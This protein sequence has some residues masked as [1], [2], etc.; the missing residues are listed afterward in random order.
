MSFQV[1]HDVIGN[2]VALFFSQFFTKSAHKFAR[3]PKCECDG[4]AQHVPTS[5]HLIMRTQTRNNIVNSSPLRGHGCGDFAS[6]PR[7]KPT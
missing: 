7:E 6:Q 1:M 4:E 2:S 3:A 5:A